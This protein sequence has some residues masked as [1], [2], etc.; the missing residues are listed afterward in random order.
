MSFVHRKVILDTLKKQGYVI[1]A[2]FVFNNRFF[3]YYSNS[4]KP[5]WALLGMVDS[6]FIIVEKLSRELI[7][8]DFVR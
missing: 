2:S 7:H 5:D 8:E 1:T 6:R 4:K 3:K